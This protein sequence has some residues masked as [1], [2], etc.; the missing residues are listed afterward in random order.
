[1]THRKRS[2]VHLNAVNTIGCFTIVEN[3]EGKILLV[4]RKDVPLWDLPGGRL[5]KHEHPETCAIREMKEETGYHVSIERK[6][7]EYYQPDCRDMQYIYTGKLLGG[8]PL[9]EGDETAKIGWFHP[10]RLP[11]FMVPHRRKQIN[12]FS[13]QPSTLIKETLITPYVIKL[14]R[15]RV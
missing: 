15:K 10:S 5:D 3:D 8:E 6:I 11:L 7:G 12:H 4:K 2:Y 9:K 14:L 1:M 13:K